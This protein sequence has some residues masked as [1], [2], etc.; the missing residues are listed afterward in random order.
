MSTR[1]LQRVAEW[2]P[3]ELRVRPTDTRQSLLQRVAQSDFLDDIGLPIFSSKR[4]RAALQ[5]NEALMRQ[6]RR[7]SF[8]VQGSPVQT[9]VQSGRASEVVSL[10]HYYGFKHA[11]IMPPVLFDLC[12]AVWRAA[13][14]VLS[15]VS[16]LCPFTHCQLL[17]YYECF[18]CRINQHRDNSNNLLLKR[19]LQGENPSQTFPTDWLRN[20]RVKQT[21]QVA[22]SD[23]VIYTLGSTPMLMTLRFPHP[24]NLF[25]ERDS[26]ACHPNF[27]VTLSAGTI[28][29]WNALDDIF[30]THEAAFMSEGRS[31]E[32]VGESGWREAYVFRHVNALNL[33]HCSLSNK[34]E[35]VSNPELECLRVKK[36]RDAV[37][38]A[39]RHLFKSMC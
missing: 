7:A 39:R 36:K 17:I 31:L 16:R 33:F 6:P 4:K 26:Y 22:G 2:F 1:L 14:H 19:L 3:D 20:P 25:D 10:Y 21:G 23:V 9:I 38:R 32:C 27:S 29:V 8:S 28:F 13:L 30:F 18:G 5:L 24:D 11:R 15:P 12:T 34:H 37:A 35:L